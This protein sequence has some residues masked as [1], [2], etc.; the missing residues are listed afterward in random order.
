MKKLA[1]D[2]IS[3]LPYYSSMDNCR[4]DNEQ[5]EVKGSWSTLLLKVFVILQPWYMSYK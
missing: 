2:R 5:Q 3:Y 1:L 4:D